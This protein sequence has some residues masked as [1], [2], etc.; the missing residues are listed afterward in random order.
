MEKKFTPLAGGHTTTQ[1]P[2][3]NAYKD[4][5]CA[6]YVRLSSE[7]DPDGHKRPIEADWQKRPHDLSRAVAWASK[8]YGVGLNMAFAKGIAVVDI[9]ADTVAARHA[10]EVAGKKGALVCRSLK[11]WHIFYAHEGG[12]ISQKGV[13]L[14]VE[15]VELVGVE[16]YAETSRQIVLPVEG[17]PRAQLGGQV[18]YANG[19]AVKSPMALTEL[20][21]VLLALP[22]LQ[23]TPV[24]PVTEPPTTLQQAKGAIEKAFGKPAHRLSKRDVLERLR[25]AKV[26]ERNHITHLA[27]V[28][29]GKWNADLEELRAEAAKL[30][31]PNDPES[32]G[33]LER[34]IQSG[35][36]F[37]EAWRLSKG[38]SSPVKQPTPPQSL[39][40][41]DREIAE[42]LLEALDTERKRLTEKDIFAALGQLREQG[43]PVFSLKNAIAIGSYVV[44]QG[45][46]GAFLTHITDGEVVIPKEREERI[47]KVAQA[48]FPFLD[49]PLIVRAWPVR[50]KTGAMVSLDTED[51]RVVVHVDW[52]KGIFRAILPGWE[53]LP[54]GAFVEWL[55]LIRRRAEREQVE[56]DL[57]ELQASG[58]QA[59]CIQEVIETLGDFLGPGSAEARKAAVVGLIVATLRQ[60]LLLLEGDSGS[61][62]TMLANALGYLKQGFGY[63]MDNPDARSF[64]QV[65]GAMGHIIFDEVKNLKPEIENAIK[66]AVSGQQQVHRRLFTDEDF[67]GHDTTGSFVICGASMG[68]LQQDT[69]R[70][71]LWAQLVLTDRD[72]I[73]EDV[74]REHLKAWGQRW[75][76]AA[77]ALLAAMYDYRGGAEVPKQLRKDTK[78]DLA[79]GYWLLCKRLGIDAKIAY[80][81]WSRMRGG[82]MEKGKGEWPTL[83]EILQNDP[84]KAAQAAKGVSYDDLTQWLS[85][86]RGVRLKKSEKEQLKRTLAAE[87]SAARGSLRSVGVD[88]QKSREWRSDT[89]KKEVILRITLPEVEEPT[90]PLTEQQLAAAL[91]LAPKPLNIGSAATAQTYESP[92]KPPGELI[93]QGGNDPP[94]PPEWDQV[95][96]HK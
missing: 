65:A 42:R 73:P 9:D 84:Q 92:S 83:L 2:S 14:R 71:A 88:I 78:A 86:H 52:V 46:L 66:Q 79:L 91:G 82:A 59:R 29:W 15:G 94:Y 72:I 74:M 57:M 27:A 50:Y 19:G 10:A 8:G 89:K 77:T 35:A 24:S 16:W 75:G 6:W 25:R 64:S 43:Y 68:R 17:T 38:T 12:S 21:K 47:F 44:R 28:M 58:L 33:G 87:I 31:G 96:A 69:I 49:A 22:P 7:V 54:R 4:T 45:D 51:G 55:P 1:A 39:P 23:V 62:K 13:T 90:I 85:E 5:Q 56:A 41:Y 37:G 11:G 81:V 76:V 34:T 30:F 40:P 36:S 70:R 48:R 61:G 93:T 3:L 67:V 63:A 95:G 53:P 20:H 26:G 32:R 80:K 18:V 60:G